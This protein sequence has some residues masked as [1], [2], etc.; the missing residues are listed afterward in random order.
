M[1]DLEDKISLYGM[2]SRKL[3]PLVSGCYIIATGP[4]I[5]W[6]ERVP[7][8]NHY[9]EKLIV[10]EGSLTDMLKIGVVQYVGT[11]MD[12]NMRLTRGHEAVRFLFR[13]GVDQASIMFGIV[14]CHMDSRRKLE[15]SLITILNPILNLEGM[16]S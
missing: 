5:D 12:L 7:F 10:R 3:I 15:R 6:I 4:E 16:H 1:I 14:S 8:G 2:D 13:A 11:S 9:L